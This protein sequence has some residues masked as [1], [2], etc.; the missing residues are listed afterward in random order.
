MTITDIP[1]PARTRA[2]KRSTVKASDPKNP[3][4]TPEQ[5]E[6]FGEELDAVRQSVLDELGQADAN[7]IRTMIRVSSRSRSLARR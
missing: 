5:L 3:D 7:Y 4:L 1:A 2:K 6:A